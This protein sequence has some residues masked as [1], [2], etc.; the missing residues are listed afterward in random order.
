MRAAEHAAAVGNRSARATPQ[1]AVQAACRV[2]IRSQEAVATA[3]TS[4]PI[5]GLPPSTP[6]T[7]RHA[8]LGWSCLAHGA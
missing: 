7:S 3:A 4:R 5:V 8:P 2:A 6:H 1:R